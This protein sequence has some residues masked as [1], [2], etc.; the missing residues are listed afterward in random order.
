MVVGKMYTKLV[1]QRKNARRTAQ[2]LVDTGSSVTVLSKLLADVLGIKTR[3]TDYLDIA[4]ERNEVCYRRVDLHIPGT[5]CF[6][7]NMR[8]AVIVREEDDFPTILGADFLQR[9][10]A[11]LD[12]RK[13]RH[14]IGADPNGRDPHPP[15]V[16]RPKPIRFRSNGA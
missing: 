2:A 16:V 3:A 8:V 15:I 7:E 6:V 5:D 9:T 12:F 13:G 14:A 11:F 4:G 1:V 10:G